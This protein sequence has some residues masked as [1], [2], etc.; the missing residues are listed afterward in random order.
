MSNEI[1]VPTQLQG[2]LREFTKSVLRDMPDDILAYSKDYFVD[3]AAEQRMSAYSLE[4]S[5]SKVYMALP[6]AQQEEVEAVFKRYDVDM[7]ASLTIVELKTM[8]S[9]LGGLFGFSGEVD[10]ST[11][12][13]LLDADGNSEISW[14]EWSHACAVWLAEVSG[15]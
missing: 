4:P 10:A 3:K 11:L 12:M 15:Q 14:Q 9:E 2:V 5:T 13:S 8:M 1:N 7:D 6:I